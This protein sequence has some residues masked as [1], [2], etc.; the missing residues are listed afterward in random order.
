MKRNEPPK[1]Q[2]R[3]SFDD[4]E[5]MLMH[6]LLIPSLF[7]QAKRQL[8][9]EQFYSDEAH[10]ALLWACAIELAKNSGG[11]LT[12]K[13]TKRRLISLLNS[14]LEADPNCISIEQE[15][16]LLS[17]PTNFMDWCFSHTIEELVEQDGRILLQTFLRERTVIDPLR[18][19]WQ[20]VGEDNPTELR[21]ILNEAVQQETKITAVK[22]NPIMSAFPENWKPAKQALTPINVPFL[23]VFMGGQAGGEAYGVLGPTGCGKTTIG[24]MIAVEGA[25]Y[26]QMQVQQKG[27]VLGH[28]YFFSYES[29]VDPEIR[30]RMIS[31]ATQVSRETLFNSHEPSTADA[32]KDYERRL[33]H[34][35]IKAGEKVH[36]EKERLELAGP[37]LRHNLWPVEMSGALKDCPHVGSGG[38]E[39][40]ADYLAMEQDNGRRIAGVVIDYVGIAVKR[41][42]ESEGVGFDHI[43]HY[44][45]GYG[46]K[47]RRLLAT[48]FN[49]P[50]WLLHQL[51]GEA[52]MRSPTSKQHHAMAAEAK[53]FADNLWY[54]FNIGTKQAAPDQKG[55]SL[56]HLTCSK[57]RRSYSG[58]LVP[59]LIIDGIV[60]AI[61]SADKLYT[62]EGGKFVKRTDANKV[63]IRTKNE[64]RPSPASSLG[65]YTSR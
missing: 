20:N 60:C 43:R 18:E 37:K 7:L 65:V 31:Y 58:D 56:C 11:R 6:I 41:Q 22:S 1:T 28:W 59:T 39:E 64:E 2:A 24:I 13:G 50:V 33:W 38:V 36:G 10:Y 47:A 51:T 63:V 54:C 57:E 53:N 3:L 32:L 61:R 29:P 62:V 4:K 34:D 48:Q 55:L 44:V 17:G 23:D 40:I 8:T 9:V 21:K 42:M 19:F 27:G 25:L 5:S 30:I 16:D 14:K 49:C 45:G 52:N 46:D 15:Q 12:E 35:N 26:E